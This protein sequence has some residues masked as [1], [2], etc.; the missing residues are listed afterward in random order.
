M[1]YLSL[2][3]WFTS[4]Y[5]KDVP[6]FTAT[7]HRQKMLTLWILCKQWKGKN[8]HNHKTHC[9]VVPS[10]CDTGPWVTWPPWP[11]PVPMENPFPLQESAN[12]PAE[13]MCKN[14]KCRKSGNSALTFSQADLCY[15]RNKTWWGMQLWENNK[16]QVVVMQPY[17]KLRAGTTLKLFIFQSQHALN[18]F[19]PLIPQQLQCLRKDTLWRLS[20][21]PV[22]VIGSPAERLLD[23]AARTHWMELE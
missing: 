5:M 8:R 22:A 15:V 13:S 3:H 6:P 14:N 23:M 7:L 16:W 10:S 9:R 11:L 2:H 12:A 17:A 20:V 1:V 21:Y 18:S 19:T 4:I